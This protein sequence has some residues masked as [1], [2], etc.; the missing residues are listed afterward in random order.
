MFPYSS[1]TRKKANQLYE[2]KVSDKKLERIFKKLWKHHHNGTKK[3]E[4]KLRKYIATLL[5]KTT[6]NLRR[7]AKEDCSKISNTPRYQINHGVIALTYVPRT[8][9]KKHNLDITVYEDDR[10]ISGTR[11]Y[12]TDLF[13]YRKGK[14]IE[15]L[16]QDFRMEF[17]HLLQKQLDQLKRL[18]KN[19]KDN[20]W[21]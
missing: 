6:Q 14:F 11:F 12:A 3:P 13:P 20:S 19:K 10:I 5:N 21:W 17:T 15:A 4:Q 1:D 9:Q 18:T 2:K 16:K 7:Q 8:L